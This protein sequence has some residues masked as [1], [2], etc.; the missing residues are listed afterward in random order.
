ML[1]DVSVEFDPAKSYGVC[2]RSGSGKVWD[3]GVGV[4][5]LV[6]GVL[7]FGFWVLGFEF[8]VFGL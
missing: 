2:G 3:S 4:W 5:D 8:L 6:L 1:R 7:G